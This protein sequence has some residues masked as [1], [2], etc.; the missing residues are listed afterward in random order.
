MATITSTTSGPWVTGATWV[1]GVAPG[2]GDLAVIANGHTVTIR[3]GD[4]VTIGTGTNTDLAI[5]TVSTTGTGVLVI[6]TGGSLVLKGSVSQGNGTWTIGEAEVNY[7]CT[8]A[9]TWTIGTAHN[10][11]NAI[12]NITGTDNTH[13]AEIYSN[14]GAGLLSFRNGGFLQGAKGTVK[15]CNFTRIGDA[16]TPCWDSWLSATGN[17]FSLTFCNFDTCGYLKNT[18][19][20]HGGASWIVEDTV[21]SASP[22][23]SVAG[24]SGGLA[25]TSG[26][27]SLQRNY[28]DGR[29]GGASVGTWYGFTIK[30]NV[31]PSFSQLSG[32]TNYPDTFSHNLVNVKTTTSMN[33]DYDTS[34]ATPNYALIHTSSGTINNCRCISLSTVRDTTIAGWIFDPGDTDATGDL[35]TLT[36]PGSARAHTVKNNLFLPNKNGNH[37]GQCV[38]GL[39]NA[40]ISVAVTHNTWISDTATLESGGPS[41]GETYLGYAG[42]FTAVKS[43]I[44][45]STV[46]GTASVFNRRSLRTVSDGCA[47]AN[48]DYNGKYNPVAGTY[49]GTVGAA[50][51]DG[52]KDYATSGTFVEML[53]ST[54]GLGAHD[55]T[56]NPSFVDSTRNIATWAVYKAAATS[57]Q[58]YQQ[59]VDAAL[60]LTATDPATY[61]P[62]LIS[63]VQDGWRPTNASFKDAGHDGVTIGALEGSF[64]TGSKNMLLLGVG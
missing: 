12:L 1:G 57:G 29:V 4:A 43:N 52:Y 33:V 48:L 39:G 59:K 3:N 9:G 7:N 45:W 40:N 41:Y 44:A 17:T 2:D 51:G 28:F 54:T 26:T 24:I 13:R 49:S 15:W 22:G 25:R 8:G 32:L 42:I 31:L 21:W 30:H 10:Q 61:I 55:V 60:A 20:I 23:D 38:S 62:D 14:S 27:R 46:S 53:S 5:S 35:I 47:A 63:Y 18:S 6:D 36:S 16:S 19:D 34:T 64:A 56:G 58:T 37:A 50:A 11:A